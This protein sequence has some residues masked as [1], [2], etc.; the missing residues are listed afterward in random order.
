MQIDGY[1]RESTKLYFSGTTD[2]VVLAK[3]DMETHIACVCKSFL[4]T[5]LSPQLVSLATL[6]FSK[7]GA[8]GVLLTTDSGAKCVYC[9]SQEELAECEKLIAK[10][11]TSTIS[12]EDLSTIDIEA[13]KSK[14]DCNTVAVSLK[15]K[16]I[17]IEGFEKKQVRQARRVLQQE[18]EVT[19]VEPEPASQALLPCTLVQRL[20]LHN[21][22]ERMPEGEMLKQSLPVTVSCDKDGI[23]I[24]G[25]AQDR[26][27]SSHTL[28]EK[29]PP[30]HRYVAFSCHKS[31]YSVIEKH[32]LQPSGTVEWVRD[33]WDS[34]PSGF[35][36]VLYSRKVKQI[37]R[38][39]KNLKV[40][41]YYCVV[42]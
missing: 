26:E 27:T 11:S 35:K 16:A 8:K 2:N 7:P 15:E 31:V 39:H 33:D 10:P 13:L 5:T 40:S 1:H 20:Y 30:H 22:L 6:F 14:V 28:L 32:I 34:K 42:C 17:V 9:C 3:K 25:I 41:D 29:V 4:S 12:V 38:V 37:E 21:L 24:M 23:Y 18:V 36:V 19:A